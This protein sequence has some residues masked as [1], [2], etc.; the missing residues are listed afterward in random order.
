MKQYKYKSPTRKINMK[1]RMII[2]ILFLSLFI[3]HLSSAA[4]IDVNVTDISN[5]SYS[6]IWLGVSTGG[7]NL[8]AEKGETYEF[9]VFVKNGMANT[10]MHNL[11]IIPIDMQFPV[12]SITPKVM[13]QIK[14]ME[15]RIFYVNV[16]IPSNILSTKYPIKFGLVSEEFPVGIFSLESEI[17]VVDRIKVELYI[18]YTL[19]ILL[20]L[21]LLFYRKWKQNK[22]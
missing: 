17:K 3:I 6:D 21:F 11:E 12:N 8:I 20:I 7:Y 10:S 4:I 13:D 22:K 9:R 5:K 19:L 15:I 1:K 18:F 2:S 14:P 16:T